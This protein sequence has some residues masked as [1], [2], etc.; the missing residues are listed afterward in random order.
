MRLTVPLLQLSLNLKVRPIGQHI[1]IKFSTQAHI[2]LDLFLLKLNLSIVA[3]STL[4]LKS[5]KLIQAHIKQFLIMNYLH[6]VAFTM[7]RHYM[8]FVTLGMTMLQQLLVSGS[9][10]KNSI[11]MLVMLVKE[12]ILCIMN[13]M[14]VLT[15][16]KLDH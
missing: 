10:K 2:T 13:Q 3:C 9:L 12:R 16:S 1:L 14:I 11:P 7:V 6:L 15:S 8:I 5:P 4:T